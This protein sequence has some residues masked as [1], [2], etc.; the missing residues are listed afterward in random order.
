MWSDRDNYM[1][2]KHIK[3][4]NIK[5]MNGNKY[6]CVVHMLNC[7]IKKKFPVNI[8]CSFFIT[9]QFLLNILIVQLYLYKLDGQSLSYIYVYV[10]M[11]D[12]PQKKK[13]FLNIYY[14]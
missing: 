7:E 4:K 6:F 8:G 11:C 5:K 2:F 13:V 1:S 9:K 3:Q 14:S 10:C 12:I